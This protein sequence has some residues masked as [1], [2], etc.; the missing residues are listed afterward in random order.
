MMPFDFT[1]LNLH[2][3]NGISFDSLMFGLS[4]VWD[5]I[6]EHRLALLTMCEWWQI[7]TVSNPENM[8]HTSTEMDEATANGTP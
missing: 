2:G 5:M 4:E 1:E 7:N 6:E 3:R 8:L